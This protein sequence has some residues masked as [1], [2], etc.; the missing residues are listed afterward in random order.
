[1]PT[2]L[3]ITEAISDPLIGQLLKADGMDKRSFAELLNNA[4]QEHLEQKLANLHEK[5]AEHFYLRAA[6]N[7]PVDAQCINCM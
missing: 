1:M 7:E 2:D 4:A 5:R 6:A 3:T